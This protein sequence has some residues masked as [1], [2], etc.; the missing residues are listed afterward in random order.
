MSD[1]NNLSNEAKKRIFIDTKEIFK[2]PLT[3]MGIYYK[4]DEN[5]LSKGYALIIG[6]KDTPYQYGFYLFEFTFPYNYPYSPPKVKFLTNDGVT[7]F[8]P[9]LYKNGRVCLSLL[10]TWSGPSWKPCQ[11]IRTILISILSNVF[12]VN[13]IEN[14]PGFFKKSRE[15]NPYNE[16]IRF[17]NID[18]AC[19]SLYL[20]KTNIN[21]KAYDVFYPTIKSFFEKNYTSIYE[22]LISSNKLFEENKSNLANS[23][24]YN[25]SEKKIYLFL[26]KI[27]IIINYESLIKSFENIKFN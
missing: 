22:Y 20:K 17:K 10:N 3:D 2:T 26:Y 27:N 11:T 19:L 12:V 24:F 16:I 25:P 7:R 18:F 15:N 14:E 8:N 6:P 5:D 1:N 4:N 13:P 21:H 23:G 9:N